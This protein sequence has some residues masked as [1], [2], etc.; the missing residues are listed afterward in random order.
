MN[1]IN[2]DLDKI[3][4]KDLLLRCLIG[5][6]E[7]ERK[8]KQDVMINIVIWCDLKEAA[9]TD[10]INRTVNYKDISKE[11]IRL[12]EKSKFLLI[13][14]LAEEIAQVCLEHDKVKRV[15]VTVEK[16]GALRLARTVGVEIN[17]KKD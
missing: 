8:E 1:S 7:W 17:R 5:I 14:T 11:I 16:P 2:E 4:I 12:V 13:E 3:V 15:N 10:D 9:K 6:N